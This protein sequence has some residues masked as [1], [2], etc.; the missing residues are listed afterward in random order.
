MR[1]RHLLLLCLLLSSSTHRLFAQASVLRERIR[2]LDATATV[3]YFAAHPDDENNQL[4]AC[5]AREKGYR[6][7]YL[8]LTRG[9]G[10]QNLIG[11]EQGPDLGLLRTE[12]LLAAR[13]ID[14]GEQ[15]FSRAYDF[16]FSK[17]AEEVFRFWNKEELL[18]D[19]VYLIRSLHP[20]IIICRFPADAR[21]GHGQHIASAIIAR[22]AFTAAADPA[23]FPDQVAKLGTWKAKRLLWNTMHFNDSTRTSEDEYVLETGNYLPAYGKSLGELA[24]ESRSQHKCQGF[25]VLPEEGS[26]K[27]YFMHLAGDSAAKNIDDGIQ[28]HWSDAP[29]TAGISKL[30][31]TAVSFFDAND[32][33]SSVKQLYAIR[34]AIRA[35]PVSP[36]REYK[37]KQIDLLILDCAGVTVAASANTDQFTAGDTV[38]YTLAIT[39]RGAAGVQCT[40]IGRDHTN[41]GIPRNSVIKKALH[42]RAPSEVSQPYFLMQEHTSGSYVAN[43][44]ANNAPMNAAAMSTTCTLLINGDTVVQTIPVEHTYANPAKG[45]VTE[46]VIVVPALTATPGTPLIVFAT[47]TTKTITYT[48]RYQSET[49]DSIYLH[50]TCI[51]G[52]A[53]KIEPQD[54]LI[55]VPAGTVIKDLAFRL[56][57]LNERGAVDALKLNAKGISTDYGT[58]KAQ[59]TI[60]YDHIPKITWFPTSEVQLRYVPMDLKPRKIAYIKGAGDKVAECLRQLGYVLDE[61]SASALSEANLKNYDIVITGIRAFNVEP[62][63]QLL[64][65]KLMH[66]VYDGGTLLQQYNTNSKDLNPEKMGPWYFEVGK[67]RVTDELAPVTWMQT[68]DQSFHSPNEITVDDF[69]GW[70]QERGVYFTDKADPNYKKLFLMADKGENELDGSTLVGYYGK[71]KFV[72]TGLSFF[73]QLPAGVNGATRLFVNLINH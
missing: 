24:A 31:Q 1:T 59:R 49:S 37:L 48:L 21:A 44:S 25:G 61:L 47:G 15:Y 10:G 53:W 8:S 11:T 65:E 45:P 38:S 63:L 34:K 26:K 55:C 68:D 4:I 19:A 12:E 57:P 69:S 30:I 33:S 50:A 23:R 51:N 29:A 17:N 43:S 54:T 9:D 70:V 13:S 58:L 46:P 39:N 18:A 42:T 6:T 72:Y 27:E 3:L 41:L 71:G 32:P 56:T 16:G 73:R 28:K 20:D 64:H 67:G 35:L 2:Q 36:M 62:S 5:F 66:Y 14:G 60:R 22:E 40:D 7:A 52:N